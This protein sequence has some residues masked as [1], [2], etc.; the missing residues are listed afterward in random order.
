MALT[1]SQRSTREWPLLVMTI[2]LVGLICFPFWQ[3][4]GGDEATSWAGWPAERWARLL[5]GPEQAACYVCF[6]WAAFIFAS[7]F[8]ETRRQRQAFYLGLL[9]VG[10]APASCKKTPGRSS[11]RST[12]SPAPRGRSS[13]PT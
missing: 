10:K 8:L 12:R 11:A 9:P 2:A 5:L 4:F 6:L 7:R 3:T 13:S 1:P